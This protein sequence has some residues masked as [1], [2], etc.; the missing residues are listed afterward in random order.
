VVASFFALKNLDFCL[1][2]I[3][4]ID[5]AAVHLKLA[6]NRVIVVN[7]GE[8]V[9]LVANFS[10]ENRLYFKELELEFV[11]FAENANRVRRRPELR[12]VVFLDQRNLHRFFRL[13][14]VFVKNLGKLFDVLAMSNSVAFLLEIR[15]T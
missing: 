8:V 4:L 15:R 10:R 14:I 2:Q 12:I 1:P 6:L 5:F 3:A 9:G 11:V 13:E 7:I